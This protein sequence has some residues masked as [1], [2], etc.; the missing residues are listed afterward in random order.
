MDLL[1]DERA[2]LVAVLLRFDQT[3]FDAFL[4]LNGGPRIADFCAIT[5]P[6]ESVVAEFIGWIKRDGRGLLGLLKALIV[7]AGQSSEVVVLKEATARIAAAQV[8]IE[9]LGC[10]SD[11]RLVEGLPIVNR[12]VLRRYLKDAMNHANLAWTSVR[13]IKVAGGRGSGR[14][15]SWYLI[16]HVAKNTGGAEALK[17]DLVSATLANQTLD[18]L[19]NT[20]VRNLKITDAMKPTTDGVTSETLA[21]RFAEELA[22]C[23]ARAAHSWSKPYWLVFDSLDR[24][25]RP[26]VKRFVSLLCRERLDGTF[27]NCV[28]FLL[29]PDGITEP[30]DPGRRTQEELLTP[31]SDSEIRDAAIELNKLGRR[32]LQQVVLDQRIG[33]AQA[34]AHQFSGPDLCREVFAKLV[35]LRIEVGA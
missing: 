18:V 28:I 19:F 33:A 32:T 26:E 22:G 6:I 11:A 7:Q 21:A 23:L 4:V 31:F 30:E 27:D 25:L 20:L 8:A 3:R 2:A 1:P 17:F 12:S 34:L 9:R 24:D 13:I 5:L 14:S 15:H 29:G 35:D 16:K 10:P